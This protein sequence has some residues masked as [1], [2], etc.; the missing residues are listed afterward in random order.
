MVVALLCPRFL[1]ASFAGLWDWRFGR[2]VALLLF[3][4]ASWPSLRSPGRPLLCELCCPWFLWPSGGCGRAEVPSF[5]CP[6]AAA[7][8]CVVASLSPAL[9]LLRV[10]L[11]AWFALPRCCGALL[12]AGPLCLLPQPRPSWCLIFVALAWLWPIVALVWFPLLAAGSVTPCPFA[13]C[14]GVPRGD[15]QRPRSCS[16]RHGPIPAVFVVALVALRPL[17]P[18]P[19][20][21]LW[22]P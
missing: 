2:A 10:L 16:L 6:V 21:G 4:R 3:P 1:P 11:M 13:R 22:F 20:F 17:L 19:L 9:Y 5:L 14:F 7:T 12:G 15:L 8:I 18:Q